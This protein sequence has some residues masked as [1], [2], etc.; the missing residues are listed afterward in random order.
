MNLA[1]L[2]A[3]GMTDIHAM[4]KLKVML[5][6]VINGVATVTFVL[7]K[8]IPIVPRNCRSPGSRPPGWHG[9]DHLFLLARLPLA[10][11]R[12]TGPERRMV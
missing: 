10:D 4:N 8:A 2:S 12:S 3:L 6:G 1:V 7:T 11:L 5:G 9:H